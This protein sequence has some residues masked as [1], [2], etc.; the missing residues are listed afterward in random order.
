MNPITWYMLQQQ[1][2]EQRRRELVGT[3]IGAVLYF[4]MIALA[5][6]LLR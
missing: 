1:R 2:S 6:F 5:L 3:I 4:G